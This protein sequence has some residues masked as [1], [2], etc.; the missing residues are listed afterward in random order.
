MQSKRLP[1]QVLVFGWIVKQTGLK[2]LVKTHGKEMVKLLVI[3]KILL[4]ENTV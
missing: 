3:V 4:F 1:N 2:F